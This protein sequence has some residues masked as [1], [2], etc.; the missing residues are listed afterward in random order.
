[1]DL[2]YVDKLA[3]NNNGV[4]NLSSC[5]FDYEYKNESTQQTLRRQVYRLFWRVWKLC[6]AKGIQIHST[7]S[8]TKAA[9]A[10]RRTRSLK[11]ILY[12]YLEIFGYKY[13]HNLPQIITT[14]NSRK[15]MLGCFVTKKCLEA[16]LFV[17]SV[18]LDTKR[19]SK[20]QA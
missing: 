18:Q 6:K 10:E 4:K 14:L 9:F 7:V 1:M 19:L 13:I 2:A 12:R 16:R 5:N 15:K 20:T 17:L 8:D 3:K 11:N